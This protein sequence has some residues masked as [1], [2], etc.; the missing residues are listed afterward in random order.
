M[1]ADSDDNKGKVKNERHGRQ[2]CRLQY[3]DGI[4]GFSLL[5]TITSKYW[6]DYAILPKRCIV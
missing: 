1:L 3:D 2:G 6:T 5:A 4:G